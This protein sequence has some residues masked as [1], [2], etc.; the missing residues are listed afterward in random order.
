MTSI[1]LSITDGDN[2][3]ISTNIEVQKSTIKELMNIGLG[4]PTFDKTNFFIV[5]DMVNIIKKLGRRLEFTFDDIVG[6]LLL[7]MNFPDDYGILFPDKEENET[8]GE[9]MVRAF[10]EIISLPII[11][12]INPD[13]G[14]FMIPNLVTSKFIQN[15][16]YD[17]FSFDNNARFGNPK[18]ILVLESDC[19]Y[20][21]G[22]KTIYNIIT[23]V[24]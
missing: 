24:L 14:K 21:L 22:T 16:D 12:M 23:M 19:F 1:V 8:E 9:Y 3:N 5:N 17:T 10:K 18:G 4:Y 6:F 13:G 2:E 20:V 11:H 15:Y 7:N